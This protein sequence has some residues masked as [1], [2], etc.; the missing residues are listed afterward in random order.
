[1]DL[2]PTVENREMSSR[3]INRVSGHVVLGLSL[4][5]MILAVGATVLAMVGRFDPSS[6]GD[7]GTAAHLFQFAI[8]LLL[9]A[10]LVF[11]VTADWH[12]PQKVAKLLLVPAVALVLA[13]SALYYMENLR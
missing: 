6:G 5:A 2:W 12:Q 4:F 10:G 3:T 9:P 11:L 7:E 1:M 8:V 13:F